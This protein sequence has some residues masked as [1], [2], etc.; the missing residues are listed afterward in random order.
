[1]SS[2]QLVNRYCQIEC[3]DSRV[4]W[5]GF[6]KRGGGGEEAILTPYYES[7]RVILSTY[8]KKHYY[9]KFML[10]NAGQYRR[11]AVMLFWTILTNTDQTLKLVQLD[12]VCLLWL[13]VQ[14]FV[15][16]TNV[17]NIIQ[18]NSHINSAVRMDY[19]LVSLNSFNST[20]KAV[21]L[22]CQRRCYTTHFFSQLSCR[23]FWL[24][25]SLLEVELDLTVRIFCCHVARHGHLRAFTTQ[26]V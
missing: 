2:R 22:L 24:P 20:G 12:P 7:T 26:R 9:C 14:Y 21:Q 4:G 3:E 25:Q 5:R 16:L 19:K 18:I 11:D 15:L 13:C 10:V 17:H 1:M 23:N 6:G 8:H